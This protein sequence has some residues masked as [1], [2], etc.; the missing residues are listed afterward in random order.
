M[1][2]VRTGSSRK[3]RFWGHRNELRPPAALR[4][5]APWANPHVPDLRGSGAT[6][7][8]ALLPQ[9]GDPAGTFPCVSVAW[10]GVFIQ[11]SFL[12]F[13]GFFPLFFF[14][15]LAAHQKGTFI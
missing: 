13:L 2:A 10:S 7:R 8:D 9:A 3:A 15:A 4:V 5:P 12:V 14:E 6:P 1:R 11:A